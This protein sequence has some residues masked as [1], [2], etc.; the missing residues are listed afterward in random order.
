MIPVG[1]ADPAA[2]VKVAANCQLPQTRQFIA[3][4]LAEDVEKNPG[5]LNDL[6]NL[7]S[8]IA[9]AAFAANVV[10][11]IA[12]SLAGWRKAPKPA[13]WDTL[14][15]KYTKR[16]EPE[17]RDRI[18]EL[19]VVFGDGRALDEVKVVALDKKADMKQRRA[20]LQT[21]IDNRAPDLR[22]I[23]EKLVSVQFLNP[24]AARGLATFDDPKIGEILVKAYRQFHQ[25]ERPQL[26]ATLVS[27]PTFGAPL[28]A[29]V[30]A[31]KIPRTDLT[32]FHAR[33]I[34]SFNDPALDR[35]LAEVW[36]E[37][38]ESAADKQQ[39]IAKLKKELTTPALA[40]ADTSAGRAT[41]AQVCATCHRLYGEG[42]E[43][44]P[45][46]TGAGRGNLDYLLE[47]IADP[48]AV[49]SADF[50]MT[51]VTLKDGRVLNGFVPAK[52]DRT[53][54]LRTMTEKLTLERSEIT[55]LQE[56]PQSLMPEGLL[57]A[58]TE[59]QIRDLF[60]YLMH[61]SQVPLPAAPPN[62]GR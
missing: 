17:L 20:A 15:T 9:D 45:D 56:L 6:L 31:G 42:G 22:E 60:A 61:P 29:A 39:L 3:R 59:A 52:T 12:E 54:T 35:K 5:P 48:S 37:L 2:L 27:R 16:S 19:S 58:L 13:A 51:V 33:Q 57:Q 18:R 49:V 34:R 62:G 53:L 50:R 21:L 36:G 28:L 1:D 23:C 7:P 8:V 43:V 24:I 32:A 47:N 14:V 44:G 10:A 26:L 30:G 4:R 11:G 25:S 55:S 41:F 40:Q 46:L 38:R